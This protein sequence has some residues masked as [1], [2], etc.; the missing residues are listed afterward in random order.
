MNL[1]F[2]WSTRYLTRSLRSLV[3]YRVDH[4]K[5]KF[6]STRGHVISSIYALVSWLSTS[7][8]VS[9]LLLWTKQTLN[10]SQANL[11]SLTTQQLIRVALDFRSGGLDLRPGRGHCA[12]FL[13]KTRFVKCLYP[14]GFMN[15]YLAID[16]HPNETWILGGGGKGVKNTPS[17]IE[18][19]ASLWTTTLKIDID[20][21][22]L[23]TLNNAIQATKSERESVLLSPRPNT[24]RVNNE[25]PTLWL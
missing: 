9:R 25:S 18:L 10:L 5:I 3:R 12:V 4:S 19:R 23:N 24:V 2:S 7:L 15:E 14:A 17:N 1:I 11:D 22:Y 21:L 13:G 16:Q 20:Y 8:L 6:I